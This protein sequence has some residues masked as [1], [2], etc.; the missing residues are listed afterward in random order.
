MWSI[1]RL[2]L[3]AVVAVSVSVMNILADVSLAAMHAAIGWYYGVAYFLAMLGVFRVMFPGL[4]IPRRYTEFPPP[5]G[6]T[7]DVSPPNV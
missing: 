2:K 3:F 7:R 6:Q 4:G 1:E 5:P